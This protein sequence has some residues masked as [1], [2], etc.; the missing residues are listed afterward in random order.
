MM[1][2]PWPWEVNAAITPSLAV[3]SVGMRIGWALVL[4]ALSVSV[5]HMFSITTRRA[6]AFAIVV[7]CLIPTEWSPS[8]WLGLAFQTPSLVLQGLCGLYLYRHSQARLPNTVSPTYSTI[9][10]APASWPLRLLVV[11]IV[12][13]WL[14]ALDTFA[15]F[16]FA[17]YSI[18]FTPYAVLASLFFAC[19]LQ[20]IS[21]RSGHSPST[22][23]YR[24][25]ALIVLVSTLVHLLWRLPS[26]NVWDALL[27]PWL[28]IMAHGLA[29]S[30][31]I[32]KFIGNQRR[33]KA[34][35]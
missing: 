9:V 1:T 12:A 13:G 35:D 18:G 3:L 29:A 11:A 34:I 17:L 14:L 10:S 23:H 2:I 15:F 7:M 6:V 31:L 5:L 20:L 30:A 22:Q 19:L 25:L 28:W 26:G 8:W 33:A 27:D 21:T 16:D 4:G 24:D 32:K